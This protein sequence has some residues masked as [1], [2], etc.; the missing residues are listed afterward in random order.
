MTGKKFINFMTIID[1]VFSFL[2][3]VWYFLPFVL[4]VEGKITPALLPFVLNKGS[5]PSLVVIIF[6]SIAFWSIPLFVI[7]RLV[8][9]FF[10]KKLPDWMEKNGLISIILN[11]ICSA[12]VVLAIDLHAIVF[13]SGI[14]YF[15]Q[16]SIA[17]Y[18]MLL[19][20]IAYNALSVSRLVDFFSRRSSDYKEYMNFKK[21]SGERYSG[22]IALV[23]YQGIQKKLILSFVGIIFTII[24]VLAAILLNDFS[25]TLL[26]VTID[27]G[28][29]LSER[30]ASIIKANAD[31]LI[32][33]EDVLIIEQ[34]KNKDATFP[35]KSISYYK[36][37]PKTGVLKIEKSTDVKLEGTK[38]TEKNRKFDESTYKML[39]EKQLIV[40]D[41]PVKLGGVVLG[42]ASVS[43]DEKVIY[44]PYFRTQLKTIIIALVFIY[45]S[46]FLTYL[47]GR[48][49]VFPI[50]FLS[51]S[52]NTISRSLA[53]MIKGTSD[54]SSELL[55]YHDRVG[56]KDEIKKLSTEIGDMTTVIRG[57][58]PYI[59]ASTLKHSERA[60]PITEKRDLCFLFTDIR[61]FTTLCEGA[62]PEEVVTMLNHFLDIQ[63]QAIMDAG[64]E[65]DKFVGDEIM[66]MF[67]GEDRELKA[68]NAAIGILKVMAEEK[69][70][71]KEASR[72]VIE[73]GLGINSG[74][75]VFGSVG[76]KRR[77]D[78]TSIGDTVNLA[79][80][81]EGANKTYGT[82]SL[83]TESVYEKVKE[84][85]LCREIDL[86][87]VK[88]KTQ[89]VR[90]YEI[91]Q[92]RDASSAKLL[93]F[94]EVFEQ[95]LKAYRDQKWKEAKKIFTLLVKDMHDE[96][97][98]IFL[99]RIE[100]FEANPPGK[101]WDGVFTMTV[102]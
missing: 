94:Q 91:L 15:L 92:K 29:A 52:V 83:I 57:V 6:S 27:N 10:D 79:A 18:F 77:M 93:K 87:T 7:A 60:I 4:G 59:S 61:G 96:T 63:T 3:I 80:R 68:C 25:H 31:D 13:A 39:P 9:T 40:F 99:K 95:G 71:S 86:L 24:V 81:L 2:V 98:N 1:A 44:E 66:A 14:E 64:G 35:F 100:L 41:S 23:K 50:L 78:F 73:I 5:L 33:I 38:D 97:S 49:I 65:I 37:D 46:I 11:I 42:F 90:I 48:S 85:Y 82:K 30:T 47:F 51:M 32:G 88:G 70:K 72:K 43:Y 21:E 28:R 89:P 74:P 34:K 16:R 58:I 56:T 69:E 36:K 22:L 67:E 76:A 55:T 19:L 8:S 75:V 53:G 54:V 20:A 12:L 26:R 84:N 101:D 17:T 45:I 102:K 62:S